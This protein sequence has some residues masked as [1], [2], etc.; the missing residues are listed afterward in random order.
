MPEI[1]KAIIIGAGPTGLTTS[2]VLHQRNNISTK[3]YEL[4]PSPSTIGGAIGIPSNGLRLLDRLGVYQDLVDCASLDSKLFLHGVNGGLLGEVAWTEYLEKK[5]GYGY[6]RVKRGD[7]VR[8]L[9]EAN[10]ERG[11]EVEFGRRVVSVSESESE[12]E[13]E[14]E[15]GKGKG[16]GKITVRFDD[17]TEDSADLLIGAD[18]IHSSIRSLYVDPDIK[19]EYTAFAV[20]SA[21]TPTSSLPKDLIPAPGMHT[22]ITSEGLFALIPC[23]ASGDELF[24]FFSRETPA[25]ES[26]DARDGWE[27]RRQEALGNFK[28]DITAALAEVKGDWGEVIRAVVKNP[29]AIQ[30]YPVYRLP[31]GGRWSRGRCIL[32]GDAAHAMPPHAGQGVSMALED[33]FALS[34]LLLQGQGEEK[35][36]L[37]DIWRRYDAVRRPRIEWV[38]RKADMYG[39]I[40]KKTGPWGLW[41]KEMVFMVGFGV[42]NWVGLGRRG[43]RLGYL[44]YDI[45]KEVAPAS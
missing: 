2:L 29:E 23:T 42:Y 18:G 21:V 38:T 37:E 8:I 39:D 40:R 36:G 33:G 19:Q 44:M 13:S 11:V 6:M 31:P 45:E 9:L 12:S 22:V 26:E 25:P 35:E 24:W 28:T 16:K 32:L 4:R 34:G 14:A 15:N 43:F 27:V 3:I 30:F 7:L 5:I 1:K 41:M 10:K 17:G 20:T